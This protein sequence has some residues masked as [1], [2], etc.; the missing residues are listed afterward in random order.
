MPISQKVRDL[1]R[2]AWDD[3]APCL[4]ATNGPDGPNI[5]V[6]GSMI[7]YDD[8][9][10]AYWERSRKQALANLGQDQRVCVIYANFKAQRDGVLDSGFLRFWGR[11]E[12]HE[13]GPIHDEIFSLLL[14]REQTHVGADTGIGVL[15]KIARSADIRGKPLP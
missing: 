8:D 3:G 14:P 13:R 12:L 1:I 6:K 10:L 2:S 15:V 9:H 11:A 4:V 7:V 5:S